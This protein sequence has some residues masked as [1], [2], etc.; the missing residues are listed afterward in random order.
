M[1]EEYWEEKLEILFIR[2]SK[3]CKNLDFKY[4]F[5]VTLA[6]PE[7]SKKAVSKAIKYK[8]PPVEGFHDLVSM[9][10]LLLPEFA[11]SE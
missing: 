2:N 11:K 9:S 10:K 1:K 5:S 6:N 7:T 3:S 8:K 4:Q